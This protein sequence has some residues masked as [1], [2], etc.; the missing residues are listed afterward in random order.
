MGVAVVTSIFLW[1]NWYKKL[2]DYTA[3]TPAAVLQ[4]T[5]DEHLLSKS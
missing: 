5:N 3:D 4:G 1:F 2:E